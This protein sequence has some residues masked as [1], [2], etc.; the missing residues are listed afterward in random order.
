MYD[1]GK[2]I[3]IRRKENKGYETKENLKGKD[4]SI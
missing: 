4:I 3:N 2:D 1:I